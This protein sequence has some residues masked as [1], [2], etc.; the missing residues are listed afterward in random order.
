M[1]FDFCSDCRHCEVLSPLMAPP[2]VAAFGASRDASLSLCIHAVAIYP[3]GTS[4]CLCPS[5]PHGC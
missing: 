4:G 2:A 1:D 5:L 3:G